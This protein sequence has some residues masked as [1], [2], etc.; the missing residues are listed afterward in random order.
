MWGEQM[1]ELANWS[2]SVTADG[3]IGN[4]EA[5]REESG[6]GSGWA[7]LK[8]ERQITMWMR[9]RGWIGGRGPVMGR[10]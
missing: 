7:G 1:D 9:M 3:R 4:W 8:M 6:L 5:G 10:G 2:L